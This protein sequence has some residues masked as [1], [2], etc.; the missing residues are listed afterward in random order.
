MRKVKWY[1][2]SA[3]TYVKGQPWLVKDHFLLFAKST[4]IRRLQLSLQSVSFLLHHKGRKIH[5]GDEC[6][7]RLMPEDWEPSQNV[8]SSFYPDMEPKKAGRM[9]HNLYALVMDTAPTRV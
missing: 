6:K 4:S 5:C 1:E 3:C 8:V 9:A 2:V 7:I